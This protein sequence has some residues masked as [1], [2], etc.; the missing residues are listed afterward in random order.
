MKK[1]MIV[2]LAMLCAGGLFAQ[3]MG[4]DMFSLTKIKEGVKSKRVGSYDRT[5]GNDDRL[6][7]IKDGEKATILELN[8]AGIINHIW[9]TIAP[10]S[11]RLNRNDIILRMYWDGND[12]PSVESPIGPFFGN[13]WDESYNF[14]SA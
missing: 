2:L 12:F 11:D 4:N 1:M 7:H 6:T 13:G 8:G 5:G 10:L 9:I 14:V 3:D